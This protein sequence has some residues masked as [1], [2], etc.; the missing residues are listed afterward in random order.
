MPVRCLAFTTTYRRP[1]MALCC[2]LQMRA[3][4][5]PIRHVVRVA[6]DSREHDYSSLLARWAPPQTRIV[7]GANARQHANHVAAIR[8]EPAFNDFDLFFKIDDDDFYDPDYVLNVVEDWKTRR[9]NVSSAVSDG[10]VNGSH[11]RHNVVHGL[12]AI[13]EEGPTPRFA[14]PATLAFDRK[15]LECLLALEP[16]NEFEDRTWRRAWIA[17]GLDI[18]VRAR[19]NY[20]CHIHGR[21]CSTSHWLEPD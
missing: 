12:G 18:S 20:L 8:A 15:G 1:H 21:N 7:T 17:A 3:Q 5:F 4:T 13:P 9:W 10:V 6:A 2:L 14:I 16:E 19:S 11:V